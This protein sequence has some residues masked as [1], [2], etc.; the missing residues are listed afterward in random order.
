MLDISVESKVGIALFGMLEK[1]GMQPSA[2]LNK[3]P[4]EK[5]RLKHGM[6]DIYH[7][8]KNIKIFDLSFMMTD[9]KLSWCKLQTSSFCHELLLA[10]CGINNLI[11]IVNCHYI[12]LINT[13]SYIN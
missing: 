1:A 2:E 10:T 6:G 12:Y 5:F 4:I 8:L 13:F 11:I 3:S 9:I 7:S